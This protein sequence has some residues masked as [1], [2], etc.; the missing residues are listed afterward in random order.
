M[1][2]DIA[3]IYEEAER[4]K[5]TLLKRERAAASRMIRVYGQSWSRLSKLLMAVTEKIGEAQRRG[6]PI[7]PAWL[8]Q[9][10]RF[11]RLMVQVEREMRKF[12]DVAERSIVAEQAAAVKAALADSTA[13]AGRVA[14]ATPGITATFTALP[15]SAVESI[16]GFL[17][18]GSPLRALLDELPADAGKVEIGRAHV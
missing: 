1:P 3:Q 15:V 4:F 6:Q 7:S 8:F 5:A 10:E 17:G 12:A 9:Q 11:A 18:N 16:A 13:L 2:D 14:A